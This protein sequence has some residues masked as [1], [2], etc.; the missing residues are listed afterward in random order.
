MPMLQDWEKDLEAIL[1]SICGQLC[2]CQQQCSKK[3]S[4]HYPWELLD[5]FLAAFHLPASGGKGSV[6]IGVIREITSRIFAEANARIKA[7]ARIE[8]IVYL[9]ADSVI[10]PNS[11]IRGPVVIGDGCIVGGEIKNSIILHNSRLAHSVYVGDSVIG[12]DCN[13]GAGTILSNQ[14]L[15]KKEVVVRFAGQSYSSG[16]KKLGAIIEDS[17]QVGANVVLNPGAYIKKGVLVLPG[18]VVTGYKS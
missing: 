17:V 1:A 13:L 4:V 16:R 2:S 10:K 11:Y 5:D 14:R 12:R 18:T 15:D 6:E 9:G 3:L 7:P 8:G